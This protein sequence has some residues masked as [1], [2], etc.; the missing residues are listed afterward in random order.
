MASNDIPAYPAMF[1]PSQLKNPYSPFAGKALPWPSQYA[2][3]PTDAMGRP[4]QSYLDAQTAAQAPQQ[5]PPVS[6]N[7]VPAAAQSSPFPQ[8]MPGAGAPVGGA[9]IAQPFG[10]LNREQWNALTPQQ[11]SA[12]QGP[13]LQYQAAGAMMPSGGNQFV[14]SGN[15]PSGS[16]PQAQTAVAL[17]DSAMSDW[18][19]MQNQPQAAPQ[20]A[21][22]AG[23]DMSQAYL[24][25]LANPGKVTTPGATV[26]QSPAPSNQSGVLQQF[27][28]NWKAGGGQ[29]Q[30]AGN[31]N[32]AGFFNALQGQV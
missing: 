27:L 22:P 11:R 26:P 1:D 25:A 8:S 20:A 30:G 31:Y 10:G 18:N 23:P 2:G 7:S 28:Q 6:L 3:M 13:M 21:A 5:A 24:N 32:N 15:N 16:N 4:I 19:R 29:T 9:P 17:S 14:A 12:A